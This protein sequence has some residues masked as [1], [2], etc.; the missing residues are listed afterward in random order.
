MLM[1]LPGD[2]RDAVNSIGAGYPPNLVAIDLSN[3]N[4]N[5]RSRK[6]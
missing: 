3:L 2:G 5:W 6:T 4:A 1:V